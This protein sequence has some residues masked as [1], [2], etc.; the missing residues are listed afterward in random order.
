MTVAANTTLDI[1]VNVNFTLSGTVKTSTGTAL[2]GSIGI[3][4][5]TT[6]AYVTSVPV[7]ASGAYSVSLPAGGYKLR[8]APTTP[9]FNAFW[10]G[11]TGVSS[12]TTVSLTAN[13]T[14]DIAVNVNFTLSGTVKTSTGTA[15]PGSIGIYNAT[16]Y[17]YVTSVPVN[18]SGAYS[19]SLPAGGYK[20]RVAPTTPGFNA[21]W[22]GGTGVSSATTV[23]L[24]AN[25]TLDIAVN[26]N[27]TLS[28][29]VKTST[30]TALPGSIGIY[31]ATTYAY[32]T[33]VPVNASGAYSVSLPAGGYKLRVAPTTPGFNAFW[34]G[35]T[36][37]SSATTVSLTANTTLDIVHP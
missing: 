19:V 23:S 37:V 6:Y 1:A 3:Y 32:V 2:P 12:A 31:N 15:L 30:G 5:A 24:T 4:D 20:L 33:S 29:T 7:N 25:T 16:T 22:Y 8:V 10:Y 28:G 35:G 14:L 27:F 18:A 21:F 17:A 36:G 9:G 13:T 11:G 34:Y 26:V